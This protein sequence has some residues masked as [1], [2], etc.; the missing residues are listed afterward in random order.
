[1]IRSDWKFDYTGSKL[2]EAAQAKVNWHTERP[3]VFGS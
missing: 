2:A 3:G 1:M